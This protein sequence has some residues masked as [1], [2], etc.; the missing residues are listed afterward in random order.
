MKAMIFSDLITIKN[1]AVALIAVVLFIGC[2][3]ALGSGTIIATAA[4][5]SVTLPLM[6]LFSIAA[7]DEMN[8]WE[9]FRLTLPMSRAQAVRGRYAS[10]AIVAAIGALAGLAGSLVLAAL[11][12]PVEQLFGISIGFSSDVPLAVVGSAALLGAGVVLLTAA[13]ALPPLMRYGVTRGTRALPVAFI[14]VMALGIII[15]DNTPAMTLLESWYGNAT[16]SSLALAGVC[17]GA[18][19]VLI[20]LGSA[21][22]AAR[23]YAKREL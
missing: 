5:M 10:M 4:A 21:A 19:V 9:R 15:V 16:S 18:V 12:G 20:Y 17:A 6:Y 13:V 22:I 11:A 1:S 7:Y 3:C 23:L 14:A 2:S 8:G